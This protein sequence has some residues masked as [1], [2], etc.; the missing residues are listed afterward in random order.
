MNWICAL[1]FLLQTILHVPATPGV[2]YRLNDTKWVSLQP[3]PIDEMKVRGMELFV[4][5]GGY[6]NVGLNVVCLGAKA[7]MRISVPKPIFFVRG[8]GSAKDV[9]L[10]RLIQKKDG[11]TFKMSHEAATVENKGGFKK[12]NIHKTVITVNPDNSFSLTPEE[13][14][15][16]GEYL[17]VFGYATA[18]FDFGI[19]QGK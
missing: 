3:A 10:V 13:S 5:T 4:E 2:Y 17:L 11:R 14:L 6:T 12:A 7:S 9:I 18:G 8:T 19:D 15:K 1:F 16:P